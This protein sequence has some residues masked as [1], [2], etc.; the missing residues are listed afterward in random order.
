[1]SEPTQPCHPANPNLDDDLEH[2]PVNVLLQPL[3]HLGTP[4]AHTLALAD[5][6]Q[7]IYR[8]LVKQHVHLG[9]RRERDGATRKTRAAKVSQ[10]TL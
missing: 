3:H 4:L 6:R 5:E 10:S 7:R 9:T 2:L 1:M 8:L